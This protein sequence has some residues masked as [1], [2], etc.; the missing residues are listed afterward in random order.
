MA[1]FFP[2]LVVII[3]IISKLAAAAGRQSGGGA[4]RPS[5]PRAAPPDSEE[6]RMR[7]FMEAV[8]LPP[9][10]PTSMAP[11]PVRPR[12]VENPPPLLPVNPPGPGLYRPGRLKRVPS[13]EPA[14]GRIAR[15]QLARGVPPSPSPMIAPTVLRPAPVT[16]APMEA[17]PQASGPDIGA[18]A[19]AAPAAQKAYPAKGL[20]VRLRN[21][22]AVREAI[23]MR[24]VLGP[25]KAFQEGWRY[26]GG[27]LG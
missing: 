13:S 19:V 14:G 8:G 3:V 17:F 21:P 10:A 25:P 26:Y 23:I 7:R 4:S 2:I 20:L 1:H 15:G 16:M 12:T 9:D 24:E 6:E 5:T 18:K 11:P 22:T 27:F